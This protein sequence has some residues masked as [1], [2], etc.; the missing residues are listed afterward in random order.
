[1]VYMFLRI[2]YLKLQQQG[3]NVKRLGIADPITF[4]VYLFSRAKA[5]RKG[6]GLAI[7]WCVLITLDLLAFLLALV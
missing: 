1:L 4:P 6:V 7:I 2:D 5:F 3:F